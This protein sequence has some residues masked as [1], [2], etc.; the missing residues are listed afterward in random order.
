MKERIS[1]EL[2]PDFLSV[3]TAAL[4]HKQDPI[5]MAA[6]RISRSVNTKFR[7]KIDETLRGAQFAANGVDLAMEARVEKC[8]EIQGHF[9]MVLSSAA[10]LAIRKD[11]VGDEARFVLAEIPSTVRKR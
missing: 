9:E 6:L 11:P 2:L 5:I 3:I 7:A 8:R 1:F 10:P 4:R